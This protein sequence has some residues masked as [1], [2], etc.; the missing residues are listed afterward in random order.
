MQRQWRGATY[1][2]T[3]KNPNHVQKGVVSVT[4]DG[5]VITGAVPIQP[6]GAHHQIEVIMG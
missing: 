2:I 3:V 6:A 5:A 4:L 1:Q